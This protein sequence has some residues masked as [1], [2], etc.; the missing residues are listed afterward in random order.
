MRRENFA[1]SYLRQLFEVESILLKSKF[2]AERD[3]CQPLKSRNRSV[4]ATAAFAL[5]CELDAI[6]QISGS[7]EK[8]Q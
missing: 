4:R 5:I 8:S 3:F 2:L 7:K 6:N 1:T